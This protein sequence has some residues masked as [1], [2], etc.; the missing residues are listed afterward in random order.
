[1]VM[2]SA[3]LQLPVLLRSPFTAGPDFD[4][5]H[6]LLFLADAA[7]ADRG[8]FETDSTTATGY[9]A[10]IESDCNDF[11]VRNLIRRLA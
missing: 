4:D 7:D 2:T 11:Q 10:Q 5:A 6:E 1:M 8:G 3:T 9:L